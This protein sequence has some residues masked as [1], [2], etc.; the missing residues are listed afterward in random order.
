MPFDGQEYADLATL[1]MARARVAEP[2]AWFKGGLRFG[3]K[4]CAIGWV[5]KSTEWTM[6][7]KHAADLLFPALPL[8]WRFDH[9]LPIGSVAFYNDVRWRRQKAIVRLFDRAIRRL[10]RR[11]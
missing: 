10:E 6:D 9:K 2:G 1:R 4:F 5:L 7:A 3:D 11:I 8:L